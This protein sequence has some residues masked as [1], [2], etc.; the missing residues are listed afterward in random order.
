MFKSRPPFV[1]KYFQVNENYRNFSEKFFFF[2][3]IVVTKPELSDEIV[4]RAFC[5]YNNFVTEK[6]CFYCI[7]D[8]TPMSY[9]HLH[10]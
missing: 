2:L 1:K 7:L 6:R 5:K 9:N 8:E 10:I 4:N 3:M